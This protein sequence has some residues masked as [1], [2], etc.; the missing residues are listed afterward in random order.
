MIHSLLAKLAELAEI[1]FADVVMGYDIIEGKLRL[2][3]ID[4]SFLDVWFSRQIKGRYAYHW[5]RRHVDGYVFRWDNAKHEI[6][7]SIKTFPNH[8]HEGIDNNVRESL[9]PEIPD[10]ALRY[11]LIYVREVLYKD[12]IEENQDG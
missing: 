9:L 6:W 2:Y 4:E 3:I 10:Q 8:F 11:V 1:E 12:K 7:K 5:E